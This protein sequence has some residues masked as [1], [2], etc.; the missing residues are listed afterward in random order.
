MSLICLNSEM[1]QDTNH[2]C[3]IGMADDHENMIS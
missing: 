3:G 2:E 1:F